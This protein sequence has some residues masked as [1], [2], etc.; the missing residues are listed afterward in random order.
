ML[1][2]T[3]TR[4]LREAVAEAEYLHRLGQMFAEEC[5]RQS[6]RA[7]DAHGRLE[8]IA[9]METPQCASIGR[10]MAAVARGEAS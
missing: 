3:T 5:D 10:R 8:Q 9:A 2:L 4:K 1:G 6:M 7:N